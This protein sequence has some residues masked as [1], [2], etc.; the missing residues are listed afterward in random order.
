MY[1]LHHKRNGIFYTNI[2]LSFSSLSRGY[3]SQKDPVCIKTRLWTCTLRQPQLSHECQQRTQQLKR[4][5]WQDSPQHR[6]SAKTSTTRQSLWHN[7]SYN[8]STMLYPKLILNS[9]DSMR[10]TCFQQSIVATNWC[11]DVIYTIFI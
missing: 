11:S 10:N 4:P 7:A 2:S 5:R 8:S 9:N 6:S 3:L 1:L